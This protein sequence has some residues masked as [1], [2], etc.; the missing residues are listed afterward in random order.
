[1]RLFPAYYTTIFYFITIFSKVNPHHIL[2]D[3]PDIYS[4]RLPVDE[5]Y[6][7]LS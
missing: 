3:S 4:S 2:K 5:N 1:M 6:S 7:P